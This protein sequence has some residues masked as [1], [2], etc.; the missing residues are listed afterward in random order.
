M[1]APGGTQ[2]VIALLARRKVG[3][4]LLETVVVAAACIG[5]GWATTHL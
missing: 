4:I 2:N 3:R 1:S 5:V